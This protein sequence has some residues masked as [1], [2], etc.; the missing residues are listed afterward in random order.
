VAITARAEPEG[1]VRLRVENTGRLG[2]RAETGVGL[3]NARERLRLLFGAD[4]TL[5]VEETGDGT[6]AACVRIPAP[7]ATRLDRRAAASDEPPEAAAR[8]DDAAVRAGVGAE[9]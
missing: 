3:A 2:T 4:A 9:R 8:A 7:V 6:V 1:G 5:T